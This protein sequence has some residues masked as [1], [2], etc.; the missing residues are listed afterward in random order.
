MYLKTKSGEHAVLIYLDSE[1]GQ[2]T[3]IARTNQGAG[4]ESSN[5]LL[6]LA[7]DVKPKVEEP[8][9]PLF[10]WYE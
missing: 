8:T 3:A 1:S 7:K 4:E 5:A 9:D 2:Y 6:N 10:S